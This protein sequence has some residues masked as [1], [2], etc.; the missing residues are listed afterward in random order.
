MQR[1]LRASC[2][3]ISISNDGEGE[4]GRESALS[5]KVSRKNSKGFFVSTDE[6]TYFNTYTYHTYAYLFVY[7]SVCVCV[8]LSVAVPCF[9]FVN[10]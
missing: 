10:C 4:G 1:T 3:N 2:L 7:V 8:W 6:H 9:A 5:A